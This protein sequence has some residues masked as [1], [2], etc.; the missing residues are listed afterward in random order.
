M[1]PAHIK[2][3]LDVLQWYSSFSNMVD[4]ESL[5]YRQTWE[6]RE[7]PGVKVLLHCCVKNAVCLCSTYPVHCVTVPAGVC[8]DPAKARPTTAP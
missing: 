4:V 3:T 6:E 2:R 8:A 5:K 7:D 1:C